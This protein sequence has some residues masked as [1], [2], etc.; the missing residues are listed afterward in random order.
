MWDTK[1]LLSKLSQHS[2]L[3]IAI[4]A[5]HAMPGELDHKVT[6]PHRMAAY[7]FVFM[8]KGRSVHS[9]DMETVSLEEGTAL[10]VLPHQVHC[11]PAGWE[12]AEACYKLAFDE[13]VLSLLPQ[14]FDFLLNPFNNQLIS[15]SAADQARVEAAL[16]PLIQLLNSTAPDAGALL[17]AHLNALLAELNYCYFSN[18]T[19][20]PQAG[21]GLSTFLD[22]K[23]LSDQRFRQQ[24]SVTEL[25]AALAVSENKLYTVVKKF[26]GHSPKEYL[27]QRTMLEAQRLLFYRQGSA[28]EISYELGFSDPDYFY[29]LFKRSTGKT[30]SQFLTAAR[31]LSGNQ[32]L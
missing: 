32:V 18:T 24:P 11:I 5:P 4:S 2:K 25:A 17:L 7:L 9:I 3:N 27:I 31:D 29:R 15:F 16:Q 23:R 19:A 14:S 12:T 13:A 21:E 26:T 30:V 1:G 22:F 8:I 10:F 28:K 20:N 6:F